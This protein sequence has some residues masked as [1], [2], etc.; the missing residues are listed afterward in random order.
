MLTELSID[1]FAIIDHLALRFAPGF[2][3]LTG[4]TGAGKS[5]IIDALHAVLGARVGADVVQ[6]GTRLA[7]IEAIFDVPLPPEPLLALFSE[8]GIEEDEPLILRREI[9]VSGRS[10]ARLNG[11]AVPLSVLAAIGAYLVD[12]HGQTEHLSVLR[13][14]RQLDVLDHFGGTMQLRAEF[15]AALRRYTDA[16][17]TLEDLRT[18]QREI[19]QRLDLLRFQTGE[20]EAA[21]LR[22]EEEADLDA[23]RHLL[24]NAERLTALA[25]GAYHELAGDTGS[26]VERAG[27]AST[28]VTDLAQIDSALR[29]IAERLQ[30]AAYE[31]EDIAQEVRRYRDA[32]E[33]DPQ[34]L[35]AIEERI[36]LLT[37]LKRKYGP[38]IADVIAFGAR[39]RAEL[40]DVEHYDDRIRDLTEEVEERA[41][42]VGQLALRLSA[43]RATAAENLTKLMAEALQGLALKGTA[44]RADVSHRTD[45]AGLRLPG[46]DERV[47]PN[48]T[49]IDSVTFLV[50]FNPGE[51]LRPLERVAS[52]GESSRFLLALKSVLA[53]ADGIPTLIFDEVDT[54]VG[55]RGGIVVGE[56]L[57]LLSTSHQVISITHLPQVAALADAHLTVTK[58]VVHDRTV[59]Q[60]HELDSPERVTELAEMMSGT[61]SD[62]ARRTA[63]ELLDAA[64]RMP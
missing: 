59:V 3:V 2:T 57:R 27:L 54:G 29:D 41:G 22:P 6:E 42:E 19:E 26:V 39:A 58:H 64:Q 25:A 52:G 18:G 53:G 1:H 13:R 10:T 14:D 49:G 33:F 30:S 17:R 32:V 11:R 60:V 45:A 35:D 23:E 4:E 15:A 8:Y 46:L 31:I 5:I 34:R 7:S 40:N 47:V 50:S 63:A 51:P 62:T 56:R 20:I 16:Q 12:I 9:S 36:D 24:S 28:T 43:R 21:A 44:F 38:T 55:G 37:R 61:G 48:L